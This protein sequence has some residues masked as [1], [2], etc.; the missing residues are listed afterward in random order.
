[1]KTTNVIENA[2]ESSSTVFADAAYRFDLRLLQNGKAAF[3]PDLCGSFLIT[4]L[5]R[6]DMLMHERCSVIPCAADS[7]VEQAIREIFVHAM[8]EVSCA[9]AIYEFAHVLPTAASTATGLLYPRKN[10]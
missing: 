10:L 2:V 5:P 3:V 9:Q 7:A 1:M 8:S 6:R 4:S